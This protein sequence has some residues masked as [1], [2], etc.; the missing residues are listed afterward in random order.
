MLTAAIILSVTFVLLGF[1][2]TPGNAKYLL[3]GYNMMSESD[4][5]KIDIVSYLR[6]FNRFHI[7]LGVS[8]FIGF[9]ILNRFNGNWATVFMVLYPL[10]AYVYM[11]AKG[12]KFYRGTSGQRSATY[13]VMAILVVV[14]VGVGSMFFVSMKNS[15][16]FLTAREL[17]I[18]GVYGMRVTRDEVVS[19]SVTDSL[20]DIA[21]RANG[22]AGGEFS[23]G[24]FRTDDGRNVKLYIN[25]KSHPYLLIKTGKDVI[26]F[27][28]D[29]IS[30]T[31]LYNQ[32]KA[33]KSP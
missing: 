3:S 15:Q 33:W 32:L 28:S 23:K 4:R 7:F 18:T 22:F 29:E 24:T 9:W 8:L 5:A 25:K 26:Y 20:P 1:C 12:S 10:L 13:I 27:S 14:G 30:A 11:V 31:E 19:F 6:F 2:V 16:I 21:S 17:E